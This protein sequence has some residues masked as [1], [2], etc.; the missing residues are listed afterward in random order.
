MN[1]KQ[2]ERL[3]EIQSRSPSYAAVTRKAYE[4]NSKAAAVKAKCLDCSGWQRKEITLC[5]V[6]TCPLWPYRPY[7]DESE[8]DEI[9]QEGQSL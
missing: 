7:Q 9:T 2:S 4:G 5:P 8:T 3:A 6:H 1:S